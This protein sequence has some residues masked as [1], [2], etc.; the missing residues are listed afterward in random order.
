MGVPWMYMAETNRNFPYKTLGARLKGM[1]EKLRESLAEVSGAVE[2]ELDTLTLIE[3]GKHR[4]SED[5]LLLLISHFALKEDEA[6]KLWELAGFEKI[7]DATAMSLDE[8]GDIKNSVIVM[9]N[10][11]RIA[12][13]DMAHVVANQYGVV[14]NF[15]QTNGPGTQPMVV[16]RLGMSRDHAK[17][18]VDLLQRTLSG[19]DQTVQQALPAPEQTKEKKNSKKNNT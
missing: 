6:T 3:Q 18:L 2:I 17:S 12:Y 15:M 13:T 14:I 19:I 8:T 11:A 9:P 7:D 5:I 16:A 4:P 10:D 1:R